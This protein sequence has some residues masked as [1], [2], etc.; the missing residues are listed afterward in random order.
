MSPRSRTLRLASIIRGGGFLFQRPSKQD[1]GVLKIQFPQ[2][3]LDAGP[4]ERRQSRIG[5]QH[6]HQAVALRFQIAEGSSEWSP[7]KAAPIQIVDAP[8]ESAL[9]CGSRHTV[10][11]GHTDRARFEAGAAERPLFHGSS[12]VVTQ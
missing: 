2:S 12:V 7:A 8:L 11:G 1:V 6:Q 9:Y 10:A 4:H 5:L 3:D